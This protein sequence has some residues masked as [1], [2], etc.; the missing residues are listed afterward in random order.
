[1]QIAR[2]AALAG[3]EVVAAPVLPTYFDYYQERGST[4][5]VAIGG[6]VRLADVAEFA[7]VPADWPQQARANLIGTQFQVW[8]EY[9]PDGRAL[10]YM[11]FP[12]A[13]ALADVAWSGGPVQLTAPRPG[14][15]P[16]ANRIAAHLRRLDAAGVEYRPLDGPRPWQQGGTGPRRHRP[17]YQIGDVA[18]YLDQQAAGDSR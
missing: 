16:L 15:P 13:C 7:P 12:R 17:G 4:E 10:E 6:P 3:H 18:T 2:Q 14:R 9:I 1:M 11:I 5:P 8:T